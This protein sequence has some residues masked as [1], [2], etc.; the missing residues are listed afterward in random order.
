MINIMK[1]CCYLLPLLLTFFSACNNENYGVEDTTDRKL[2]V[3]STIGMI[4]DVVRNVGGD[5]IYT[6]GI[7][8]E[9]IDPHLY[10]P[11]AKRYKIVK[12]SRYHLL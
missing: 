4:T 1:R 10:K 2:R 12:S 11:T 6:T 5:R 9:G 7:I 3:V 8:G